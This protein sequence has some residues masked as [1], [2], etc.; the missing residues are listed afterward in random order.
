M[1]DALEGT[2]CCKLYAAKDPMAT[3]LRWLVVMLGGS[4]VDEYYN[5]AAPSGWSCQKNLGY[6]FGD[7]SWN[8]DELVGPC[9]L[10]LGKRS[11]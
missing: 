8:L 5:V 3:E 6:D 1:E 2:I 9:E 10:F 4:H 11:A 7:E